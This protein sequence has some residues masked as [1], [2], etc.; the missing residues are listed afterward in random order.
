MAKV[1][2]LKTVAFAQDVKG[3][4]AGDGCRTKELGSLQWEDKTRLKDR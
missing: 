4:N 2:C 3:G 1:D